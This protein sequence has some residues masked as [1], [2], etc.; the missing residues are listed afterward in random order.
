M[1]KAKGTQKWLRTFLFGKYKNKCCKCGWSQINSVSGKIP[2]EVNHIDGDAENCKEENLELICPNC[3]SLTP[4]FRSLNKN[5][6][7]NR[8][9]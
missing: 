5:S 3:H 2:L 8:K 7:R 9:I 4:N 1:G 6:K